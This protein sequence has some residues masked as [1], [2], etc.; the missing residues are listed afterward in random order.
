MGEH[1]ESFRP[2]HRGDPRGSPLFFAAYTT[3]SLADL[4]LTSAAFT[5]QR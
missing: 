1:H 2:P 3:M 4:T 5:G